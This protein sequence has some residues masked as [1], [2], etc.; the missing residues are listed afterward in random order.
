MHGVMIDLKDG[1]TTGVAICG[2]VV[3]VVVGRRER[4]AVA[5][6]LAGS[7]HGAPP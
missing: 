6:E 1:W 4:G 7:C 2:L 5:A 3:V